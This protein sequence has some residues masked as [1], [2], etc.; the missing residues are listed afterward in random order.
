MSR[1]LVLTVSLLAG[2][3]LTGGALA[4]SAYHTERVALVGVAGAPGGGTVV[5]V[6]TNGPV[7][8]A[9]EIYTLRHAVAGTYQVVLN[10]FPTSLDC[11]GLTVALPTAVLSTNAAGN[12]QADAK[13]TPADAAELRGMTLSISW[14]VAGPATYASACAV[15]TLD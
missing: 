6:H 13:F 9:H 14:T 4:D 2:A 12:G 7:I 10:I 11:T 15:V 8:Y 5:N 3:C 1:I